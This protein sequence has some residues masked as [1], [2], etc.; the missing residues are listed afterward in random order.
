[1]SK[2][3]DREDQDQR[4]GQ[5]HHHQQS[6]Q[7]CIPG[8]DSDISRLTAVL[9]SMTSELVLT[10]EQQ[11]TDLLFRKAGLATREDLANMERRLALLIRIGAVPAPPPENVLTQQTARLKES[12]DD[13]KDAVEDNQPLRPLPK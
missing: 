6:D 1:M 5:G 9:A 10:R 7:G 12:T 11:Q 13:L 8:F 4:Q 3:H 2:D